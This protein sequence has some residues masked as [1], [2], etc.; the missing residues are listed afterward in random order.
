MMLMITDVRKIYNL[1]IEKNIILFEM[2]QISYFLFLERERD[3]PYICPTKSVFLLHN[4]YLFA[5][6]I[7]I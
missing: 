3:V 7:V 6:F 5:F 4:R 2:T 1:C